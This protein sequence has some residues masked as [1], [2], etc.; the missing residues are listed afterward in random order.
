MTATV[1][2]N[3]RLDRELKESGDAALSLI[4]FTPTQA[5]RA[6]WEKAARRGKDLEEVAKL[7]CPSSEDTALP[8]DDPIIQGRLFMEEAYKSLGISMETKYDKIGRAHV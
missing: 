2:L 3:A 7:L 1:Q 6:L 8:A 4:G 5:V